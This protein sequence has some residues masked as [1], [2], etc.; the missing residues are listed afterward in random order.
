M[1]SV[2]RTVP[3]NPEWRLFG[4]FFSFG[5]ITNF[6]SGRTRTH[7][8]REEHIQLVKQISLEFAQKNYDFL[9]LQE[10]NIK[11]LL[12]SSSIIN[13]FPWSDLHTKPSKS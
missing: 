4:F 5:S 13:F 8:N 9:F 10:K 2:R 7:A 1:S 12:K 11:K 3:K 6:G